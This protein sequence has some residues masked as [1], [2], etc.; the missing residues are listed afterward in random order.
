MAEMAKIWL[1]KAGHM[2]T[3]AKMAIFEVKIVAKWPE[4]PKNRVAKI[5][6]RGESNPG[7][8]LQKKGLYP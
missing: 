4:M 5:G 3:M 2:V 8:L 1:S 6:P 7:F